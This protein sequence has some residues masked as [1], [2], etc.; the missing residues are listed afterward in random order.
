MADTNRND[1]NGESGVG[2]LFRELESALETL[3]D[4][5][6]EGQSWSKTTSLGSEDSDLQ[7]V[8]DLDVRT[9]EAARRGHP[10]TSSPSADAP[11]SE[12]SRSTTD[13]SSDREVPVEERREPDV[14]VFDEGDHVLVI[15]E[16]P[17]VT[18][19]QVDLQI[20][21]D[22]LALEASTADRTYATEVLLPQEVASPTEVRANNGIVKIL[23]PA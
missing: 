5:A 7:G 18:S 23:C 11:Q 4:L 3:G 19:D 22:V 14:D 12:R 17:G 21:G 8:F 16:M 6:E 15:A 20:D 13:Q 1:E 10:R 2:R 9:G